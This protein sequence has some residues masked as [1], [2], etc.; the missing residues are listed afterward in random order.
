MWVSQKR[1][2]SH[3]SLATTTVNASSTNSTPI[4]PL[5]SQEIWAERS[6]SS[7]S[8]HD[9]DHQDGQPLGRKH[10]ICCTTIATV[11]L[12]VLICVLGSCNASPPH[13][14]HHLGVWSHFIENGSSPHPW[15]SFETENSPKS[16]SSQFSRRSRKIEFEFPD[17]D[18][19]LTSRE[20]VDHS[21]VLKT[22]PCSCWNTTSDIM[23]REVE[24][25]CSEA[26]FTQLYR[27][28]LLPSDVH[29]LTVEH[30]KD[31]TTLGSGDLLPY[32]STLS[33]LV[34]SELPQFKEIQVGAFYGMRNLNTIYIHEAA[35]L[36][37]ISDDVFKVF[38]PNLKIIRLTY[39]GLTSAPN[40]GKLHVKDVL[41]MVEFENGKISQ[42]IP[43]GF[44][45]LKTEHL[46]LSYNNLREIGPLAFNGSTIARLGLNGNRQLTTLHPDSFLGI[47][48]L[49]VLD[50]SETS[51]TYLPT[52]GL[53]GIE[54]LK[55]EN[56]WTLNV[57]PS[58]Y[59]F[60]SLQKA[61]L[62]WPYHCCAFAN[63]E[64]HDP[65]TYQV[66]REHV[67][68]TVQE[69][70][71]KA[72]GTTTTTTT[73]TS[74]STE[75]HI[76]SPATEVQKNLGHNRF[77]R[78]NSRL[79]LK[80]SNTIRSST[81]ERRRS[82]NPGSRQSSFE[83]NSA[84]WTP[85]QAGP[86]AAAAAAI[87][88]K[89][90]ALLL[91][92]Q[93]RE[94]R[95]TRRNGDG[96]DLR[97]RGQQADSNHDGPADDPVEHF[98]EREHLDSFDPYSRDPTRSFGD[99]LDSRINTDSGIDDDLGV[100]HHHSVDPSPTVITHCGNGNVSMKPKHPKVIC[101]PIPDAF[102][103]CEDIMGS[104]WLR[105]AVWVVVSLALIGNSAVLVVLLLA[106]GRMTVQRVLMANLSLA[107]LCMGIYLLMVAT[108]DL[109][110]LGSYFNYAIDWQ[111]GWGCQIAGF[112]TVFASELSVFTLVVITGER[113]YA[114]TRAIHLTKRLTIVG[115]CKLMSLGW[116]LSMV[117]AALPLVG[118]SSYSK[119]S[120][121]LP[122]EA[123]SVGSIVYLAFLLLFNG[124]AFL[125]VA[126]AYFQMY[127][128]VAGHGGGAIA[129]PGASSA[130]AAIAQKM[131]ILVFSDFACWAPV[132]FFG[133][134]AVGGYPLIGVTDSK[135]L[136]VFF[137]PLNALLNPYL[138]AITTKQYRRDLL[139]LLSR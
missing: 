107:D 27:S 126:T 71:D 52:Q 41:H 42:L 106:P 65:V 20:V 33:E 3:G 76:S 58:I 11:V 122:M 31:F 135:I 67:Q 92:R 124:L 19:I 73:M 86:E 59:H 16:S 23:G 25:T 89:E 132:A 45:N 30:A 125:L 116:I 93:R 99:V 131:S 35:S 56:V 47:L 12:F 136:L 66:Y 78:T 82:V 72:S 15:E 80:P 134:T 103:P 4:R 48:Y 104:V 14:N 127:R 96:G 50:L 60:Q 13:E 61:V 1:R 63:P 123:N 38:L 113:W 81:K 100:F 112:L 84:I 128:A 94:S 117:L 138:Y 55:L 44:Y 22:G 68:A 5:P 120:I 118:V 29:R 43:G 21:N 95:T 6:A 40:L 91:R 36:K 105:G 119:T 111:L 2:L 37:E 8:L 139:L 53:G 121:C 79:P 28:Y 46:S 114:L 24:C 57:I 77:P 54:I 85:D 49:R 39:T 26:N 130:D 115:A 83:I 109:V 74:S 108:E 98:K 101:T 10:L 90:H 137:Y 51:I 62:T 64:A 110:S 129:A 9:D 87:D 7:S 97:N 70:C 17:G 102:N 18:L 75:A 69:H 32:A 88:E 34:L 133:L